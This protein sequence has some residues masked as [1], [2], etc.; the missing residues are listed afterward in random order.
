MG[1]DAEIQ[2][3]KRLKCRGCEKPYRSPK[4]GSNG[5]CRECNRRAREESEKN[6]LIANERTTMEAPNQRRRLR[7]RALKQ[8]AEIV[9][10][11]ADKFSEV[12]EICDEMIRLH[13]GIEKFCADWKAQVDLAALDKPG[14]KVVL[15]YYRHMVQLHME[16]AS[17]RPNHNDI[18]EMS[19]DDVSAEI[20][21][22]TDEMGLNVLA[23]GPTIDAEFELQPDEV[24]EESER[25]YG[26]SDEAEEELSVD[27][28][29]ELE[30]IIEDDDRQPA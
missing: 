8:T 11:S 9:A 29:A 25:D 14:G 22:I 17:H 2:A 15:D 28:M 23:S 24:H 1:R 3:R 12:V 20:I 16:A 6:G 30:R 10:K 21:R 26:D 4:W 27:E 5:W 18:D 7:D 13:G 19:L